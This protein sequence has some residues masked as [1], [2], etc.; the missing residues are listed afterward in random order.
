MGQDHQQTLR[1][2]L[3][4]IPSDWIKEINEQGQVDWHL[5]L[6]VRGSHAPAQVLHPHTFMLA[7]Y[8]TPEEFNAAVEKFME[9][10]GIGWGSMMSTGDAANPGYSFIE[11]VGVNATIKV[12][13]RDTPI[14]F[15][16]LLHHVQAAVGSH[17]QLLTG[18]RQAGSGGSVRH[19]AEWEYLTSR[20]GAQGTTAQYAH[21]VEK[22]SDLQLHSS[23]A[24]NELTIPDEFID[25]YYGK[26]YG[27]YTNV[28]N[29]LLTMAGQDT[30]FPSAGR[31]LRAKDPQT[32]QWLLGVM[33]TL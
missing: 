27:N 33:A 3:R 24:E 28:Y 4:L 2:V 21:K 16:E 31:D 10:K 22:M 18:K 13:P 7:R 14:Y 26:L 8:A 25:P 5:L 29:E 19:R 20:T 23:Y 1:D 9:E 30:F 32:Q 15:H 6:G 12:R 17:D 11:V